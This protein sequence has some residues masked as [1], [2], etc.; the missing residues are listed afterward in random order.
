MR[1]FIFALFTLLVF[2]PQ[3]SSAAE[4]SKSDQQT[5]LVRSEGVIGKKIGEY[6][7]IDQDGKEFNTSELIGKPFVVSFIYT[8][9]IHICPTIT[10][11]LSNAVTQKEKQFGKDFRFLT[12][13]FDPERD[14]PQKLKEFGSNFTKDFAH[15]RFATAD[16]ETIDRMAGDFGFF[17]KKEGDHF[18]HINVVSVVDANGNILT[19]VYGIDFKPDLVLSPIYFPDQ[20]KKQKKAGVAGLFEK[21]TLFCYKYDPAT[22]T[23][24]LDYPLLLQMTLEGTLLFSILFFVWKKEIMRFFSRFRW[25]KE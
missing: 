20:Y 4:P 5:S 15:W 3:I 12:V 14:T 11:N 25:K 13:S 19:H 18:Q 10:L 22:N 1:R 7:L 17:F 6:K 2:Y 9:C 16:K 24:K 8:S 21:V 23:Y